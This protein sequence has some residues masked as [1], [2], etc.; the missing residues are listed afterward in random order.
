MDYCKMT[1]GMGICLDVLTDYQLEILQKAITQ[2]TKERETH[3]REELAA[4]YTDKLDD[5]ADEILKK[6][7]VICYNAAPL[8]IRELSV[9]WKDV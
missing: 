5:L 4:E 8:D 9:K 2:K 6:G 1:L 3:Y 7:M